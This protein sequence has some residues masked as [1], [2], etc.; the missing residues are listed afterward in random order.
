MHGINRI[1]AYANYKT[2]EELDE[3][4]KT[5]DLNDGNYIYNIYFIYDQ[6]YK[7]Y[8]RKYMKVQDVFGN[9]NG[10][11]EFLILIFKLM[12]FYTNCRFDYFLFNELVDVKF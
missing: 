8:S 3:Y 4:Y 12:S 11:M 2:N 5:N 10:F 6:A 9:V 7:K 1:E